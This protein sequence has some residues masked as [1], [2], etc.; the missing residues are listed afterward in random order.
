[1]TDTIGTSSFPRNH[2]RA[3]LIA[4]VL[5]NILRDAVNGWWHGSGVGLSAMVRRFE[6]SI[7]EALDEFENDIRA[8]YRP[9]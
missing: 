7:G 5:L 1:V 9:D 3:A 4:R 6:E 8:E 2:S